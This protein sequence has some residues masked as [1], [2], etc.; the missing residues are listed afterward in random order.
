MFRKD[1]FRVP[2]ASFFQHICDEKRERRQKL[3]A[4]HRSENSPGL[5][6]KHLSAST[7][8]EHRRTQQEA[9]QKTGHL[10]SNIVL[11]P[12][13]RDKMTKG[14]LKIAVILAGLSER[15]QAEIWKGISREASRAGVSP[16]AFLG[17]F[18]LKS[19]RGNEEGSPNPERQ[20]YYSSFKEFIHRGNFSGAIILSGAVSHLSQA[21]ELERL[22]RGLAPLPLVSIGIPLAGLPSI[23]VDNREQVKKL[24][25]HLITV[26][27]RKRIAYVKGPEAHREAE[28]RYAGYCEALEAYGIGYDH[29]LVVPGNFSELSGREAV[30]HLMNSAIPFDALVGA[31]DFTALGA[32]KE[33]EERGVALPGEVMLAGFDDCYAASLSS[34]ALTTVRQDFAEQGAGAVRTLLELIEGRGVVPGRSIIPG[35]LILRESCRCGIVGAERGRNILPKAYKAP[36]RLYEQIIAALQSSSAG[37]EEIIPLADNFL[38]LFTAVRLPTGSDNPEIIAAPSRLE[39]IGRAVLTAITLE[40]LIIT[41]YRDLPSLAI[42]SSYLVLSEEGQKRSGRL[43]MGYNRE[44]RIE[45]DKGDFPIAALLPGGLL[46]GLCR[47]S[48]IFLPLAFGGESY[49]YIIFEQSPGERLDIYETLRLYISSVLKS[50]YL[51][52]SLHRASR[53]KIDFFI[54]MAH[55]IKTPLTLINNYLDDYIKGAGPSDELAVVRENVQKLSDDIINI[56]D[57][58]KLERGQLFYDHNEVMEIS[59]IV[60]NRAFLFKKMCERQGVELRAGIEKGLYCRFDR[61]G[62]ERVLNNLL[63]NALRYNQPGGR[64]ELTLREVGEQVELVVKD[65]GIGIAAGDLDNIFRPYYQLSHR[66]KEYPGA[67]DGAQHSQKDSRQRWWRDQG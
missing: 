5:E 27:D 50:I 46:E 26:H 67:R 25:S 54:N 61:M 21:G 33:L 20:I 29:K 63:E 43:V 22:V 41:L 39:E 40:E 58:E 55:E 34:P 38:E 9:L 28:E 60:E 49:G 24:V 36:P 18:I 8:Q 47:E 52:Q 42:K 44:G 2:G 1:R 64:I 32:L 48:Y 62:C 10:E 23:L 51:V 66:K 30:R 3:V 14:N 19:R 31:D 13:R 17:E 37:Q 7:R 12:K 35:R 65:T 4:R 59:G 6:D 15:C 11:V 16:F 45:G 57:S 53:E 56:L